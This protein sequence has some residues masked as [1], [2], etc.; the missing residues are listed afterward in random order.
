MVL[1][2]NLD[3]IDAGSIENEK[4]RT[5]SGLPNNFPLGLVSR[6]DK[7]SGKGMLPMVQMRR[8]L[9]IDISLSTERKYRKKKRKSRE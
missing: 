4:S 3:E 1:D 9:N 5:F 2:V 6:I 8:L 7:N